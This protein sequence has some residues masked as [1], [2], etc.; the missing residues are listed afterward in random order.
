MTDQI[1]KDGYIVVPP[2][3][4]EKSAIKGYCCGQ[5]GAKFDLNTPYGYSCPHA[6]CPMQGKFKW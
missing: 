3:R 2:R 5:C 6:D 1:T 4:E